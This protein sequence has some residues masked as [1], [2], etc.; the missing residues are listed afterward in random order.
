[1]SVFAWTPTAKQTD[2]LD[3]DELAD[4]KDPENVSHLRVFQHDTRLKPNL[5]VALP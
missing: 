4:Y 5:S 2:L 1:M 3:D